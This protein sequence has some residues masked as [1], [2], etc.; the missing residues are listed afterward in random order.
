MM[1]VAKNN[2]RITDHGEKVA[3]ELNPPDNWYF[4]A[5]STWQGNN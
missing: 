5:Q 2:F 1:V 3:H 4:T